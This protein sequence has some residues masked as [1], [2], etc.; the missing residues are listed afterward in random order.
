MG[1]ICIW[2]VPSGNLLVTSDQSVKKKE[3]DLSDPEAQ[4]IVHECETYWMPKTDC[5]GPVPY[6]K[7]QG[8]YK[9][10]VMDSESGEICLMSLLSLSWDILSSKIQA[11]FREDNLF[12]RV[13]SASEQNIFLLHM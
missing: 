8:G 10:V 3:N 6:C 4:R 7:D 13:L 11:F 1:S 2:D 5:Q 9:S 12:A